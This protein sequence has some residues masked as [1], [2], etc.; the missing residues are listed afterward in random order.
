MSL[1]LLC[2]RRTYGTTTC[3]YVISVK[4]RLKFYCGRASF[5]SCQ[6]LSSS[7]LAISKRFQLFLASFPQ[8]FF[9][10][11]VSSS[12]A[13]VCIILTADNQ[14]IGL[15][16]QAQLFLKLISWILQVLFWLKQV[17]GKTEGM[18][19]TALPNCP[20]FVK[21]MLD[22]LF[23]NHQVTTEAISGPQSSKIV[24]NCF[25][26]CLYSFLLCFFF[27]LLLIHLNQLNADISLQI[28]SKRL[29]D[30]YFGKFSFN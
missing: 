8:S 22:E 13:T 21:T 24:S 15:V 17:N 25:Y 12:G 18:S 20:S 28:T 27:F 29:F 11:L 7:S 5:F 9:G 19:I 26:F 3:S 23:F 30:A 6:P 10:L 4:W 16:Q 1:Q 14:K 2:L